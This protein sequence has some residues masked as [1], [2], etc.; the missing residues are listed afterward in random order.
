MQNNVISTL[1]TLV[2]DRIEE[3]NNIISTARGLSGGH[4]L[5]YNISDGTGVVRINAIYASEP[6]LVAI[7]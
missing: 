2:N 5:T 6:S 1:T 7:N 4:K 3:I